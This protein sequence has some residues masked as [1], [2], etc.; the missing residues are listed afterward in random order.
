MAQDVESV[1]P[2]LVRDTGE[3][4]TLDYGNMTAVLAEAIKDLDTKIE[5]QSASSTETSTTTV[6]DSSIT[7]SITDWLSEQAVSIKDGV[8]TAAEGVFDTVETD[9]LVIDNSGSQSTSTDETA[10]RSAG[11]GRIPAGATSTKIAN[12]RVATTSQVIVTFTDKKSG[13]HWVEKA[14]EAFTVNTSKAQKATTTFDYLVVGV[15]AADKQPA[16]G[17][18]STTD[19]TSST[20]TDTSNSTDLGPMID[21]DSFGTDPED[22]EDDGTTRPE[23][24]SDNDTS[25]STDTDNTDTATTTDNTTIDDGTS[26]DTDTAS[27]TETN[28]STDTDTSTTTATTTSADSTDSTEET[29]DTQQT[30]SST[31]NTASS[32][33]ETTDDTTSRTTASTTDAS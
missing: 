17:T 14:N 8:V 5:N 16:S 20:S 7:S 9:Q 1:F 19:N 29:E 33:D 27:S 15:K 26:D 3:Y 11:S 10:D 31:D 25:T 22:Q 6:T 2:Q 12:N 28:T 18:T 24:K 13:S 4:K 23:T 30:A 32:T 21:K